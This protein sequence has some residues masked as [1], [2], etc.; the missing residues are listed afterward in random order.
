MDYERNLKYFKPG[1][2]TGAVILIIIGFFFLFAGKGWT[3]LGILMMAGG[4]ALIV[5]KN[6]TKVTDQEYDSQ[7]A[8]ALD[9]IVARAMNK[10][11]LDEDEITQIDP[12]VIR[13]YNYENAI[14]VQKDTT[15]YDNTT[16]VKTGNDGLLRSNRFYAVVIFAT[17]DAVHYYRYD[18]MTTSPQQNEITGEYFY[19]DIV[20]LSVTEQTS[21][22]NGYPVQNEYLTLRSS[23]GTGFN[24]ALNA[25]DDGM[26]RSVNALRSLFKEKKRG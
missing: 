9:G 12:I 25:N 15:I 13:N 3:F 1:T 21:N 23:G 7:I 4:I 18:F 24:I 11:G 2:I 16:V 20:N 17:D 6:K 19:N 5:H 10:L 14:T 8:G 26:M 22:V